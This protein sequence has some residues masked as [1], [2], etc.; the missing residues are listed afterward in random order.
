MYQSDKE[1]YRYVLQNAVITTYKKSNK[2]T[3]RRTNCQ[4]I[5]CAKE[6][7]ILDK[8]EVNGTADCFTP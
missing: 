3:K 8:V 6:A 5:R 2:E 7:N 1:E 4:G